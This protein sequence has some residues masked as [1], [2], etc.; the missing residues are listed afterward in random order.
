MTLHDSWKRIA[1]DTQG[2]PIKR[3]W[4]D[5]YEKEKRVYK[6]ILS[7]KWQLLEGTVSELAEKLDLIATHMVVFVEGIYE[8]VDG[9]PPVEDLEADTNIKLDIDF[10]RL[11]KQMVEYKA[12]PL[13]TLPEWDDILTPDEQHNY[14]K[15]Q[16]KAKTIVRADK[17][18][19]ND[20]CPC[21]SGKKHKKCCAS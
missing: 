11:Y 1:Y 5:Y 12:K 15:E 6:R 3:I 17:V 8:A 9:L 16:K 14:Y 2:Q 18:G 19:R 13:Y 20:P 10:V 4:D 21:G 7:E